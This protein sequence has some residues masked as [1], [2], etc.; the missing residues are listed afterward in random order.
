MIGYST[1]DAGTLAKNKVKGRIVYCEGTYDQESTIEELEGLGTIMTYEG[2]MDFS[3][4]TIVPAT[5]VSQKDGNNIDNYI[6][7]TKYNFGSLLPRI[8]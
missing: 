4:I 2:V 6:N 7:S 5:Y 3:Y 8:P 1:C